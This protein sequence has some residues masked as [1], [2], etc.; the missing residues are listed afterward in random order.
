MEP[1]TGPRDVA[2]PGD[3]QAAIVAHPNAGAAFEKLACSH[4]KQYV[5]WI[6]GAKQAATRARRIEKAVAMLADGK[7]LNG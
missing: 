6:E 5:D 1:D 7:K 4:R 3:L 2:V